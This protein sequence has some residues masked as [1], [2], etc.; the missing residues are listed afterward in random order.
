LTASSSRTWRSVAAEL[1][2]EAEARRIG[3]AGAQCV[4][5]EVEFEPAQQRALAASRRAEQHQRGVARFGENFAQVVEGLRLRLPACRLRVRTL[6]EQQRQPCEALVERVARLRP[7]DN[8]RQAVFLEAARRMAEDLLQ[9]AFRQGVRQCAGRGVSRRGAGCRGLGHAAD[10]LADSLS[11]EQRFA[12][13]AQRR[14][15][16]GEVGCRR[17]SLCAAAG[18]DR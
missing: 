7:L 16:A 18:V 3:F 6:V 9:R 12:E 2:E 10:F 11:G 13:G 1:D 14:R 17:R 8:P 4:E 5:R 15:Q